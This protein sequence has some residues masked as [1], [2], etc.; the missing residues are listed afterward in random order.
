MTTI[1]E[2]LMHVTTR[3]EAK[4]GTTSSLGTGFY[5]RIEVPSKG[6]IDAVITN[7]HVVADCDTI[8][9]QVL[10]A[11]EDGT[12][13]SSD[14]AELTAL[15]SN[16]AFHPNPEID[17]A[18]IPLSH[19]LNQLGE[20]GKTAYFKALSSELFAPVEPCGYISP[21]EDV[22]MIGYPTGLW[23]HVN[24]RPIM[25]TGSTA[26]YYYDNFQGQPNFVV[27]I[28]AFPGS[29]GSPVFLY[30]KGLI[31]SENGNA[32]SPGSRVQLLGVLH[33]GPLQTINGE[34]IVVP[35]PTSTSLNTVISQTIN[36]GYVV[37]ARELLGLE[38]L[39]VQAATQGN[40]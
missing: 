34:V 10:T 31:R 26:T 14:R 15:P 40:A 2:D 4:T 35:V 19:A 16:I 23:D 11:N 7:R 27:D 21:I 17:L 32:M 22:L 38:G 37:K 12:P 5:Y 6:S 8:H 20:Q 1:Q 29:S 30:Q 39:L 3:I 33:S 24:N 36:L 18:A 13:N 28:A 9:F 25:R